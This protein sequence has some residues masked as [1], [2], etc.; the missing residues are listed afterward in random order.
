MGWTSFHKPYG[1]SIDEIFEREFKGLQAV[2]IPAHKDANGNNVEGFYICFVALVR[3]GKGEF[4]YKDMIENMLP[5]YFNCPKRILD[6]VEQSK[7][8]ND[9]SRIWRERCMVAIEKIHLP[10]SMAI[11]MVSVRR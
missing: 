11:V 7:P 9:N 8:C 3:M 6:I 10:L 1:L 2:Y 5:Y 4:A